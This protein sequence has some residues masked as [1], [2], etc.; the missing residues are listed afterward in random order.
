[1]N[2]K[3]AIHATISVVTHIIEL[4]NIEDFYENIL[5]GFKKLYK[6]VGDLILFCTN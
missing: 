1:M 2:T 5:S 3:T 6:I 4:S